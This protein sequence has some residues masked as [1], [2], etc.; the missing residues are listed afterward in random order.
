MPSKLFSTSPNNTK[1]DKT[2]FYC[3]M[4][5]KQWQDAVKTWI[6]QKPSPQDREY[7]YDLKCRA[8]L[9]KDDWIVAMSSESEVIAG[10]P[11]VPATIPATD[12]PAGGAA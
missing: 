1:M 6:S 2:P 9:C 5:P 12:T 3:G 7:N 4:T 11:F 10:A 8:L